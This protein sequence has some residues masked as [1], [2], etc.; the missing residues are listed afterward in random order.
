[1]FLLH[2]QVQGCDYKKKSTM[3]DKQNLKFSAAF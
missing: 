2:F 3:Q 1:M